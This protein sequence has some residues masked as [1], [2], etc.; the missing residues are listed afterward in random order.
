MVLD[1]Q[2]V[3]RKFLKHLQKVIE[4]EERR[5]VQDKNQWKIWKL[6]KLSSET[7]LES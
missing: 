4:G 5:M 6:E 1:S 7:N 3:L 2:S